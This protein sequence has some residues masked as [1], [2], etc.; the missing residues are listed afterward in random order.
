MEL[1]GLVRGICAGFDRRIECPGNMKLIDAGSGN[2]EGAVIVDGSR[3]DKRFL[4]QGEKG[5]CM[6]AIAEEEE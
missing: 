1:H 2:R 6:R 5:G 4:E 3:N